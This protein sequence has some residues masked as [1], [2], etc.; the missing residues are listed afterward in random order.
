MN[1]MDLTK[2][3]RAQ[4]DKNGYKD[5][6]MKVIGDVPWSTVDPNNDM[7]TASA[8]MYDAFGVKLTA[9]DRGESRARTVRDGRDT[10][11]PTCSTAARWDKESRR[12][13]ECRSAGEPSDSAGAPMPPPSSTSLKEAGKTYGMAGA[14]KSVATDLYNYAGLN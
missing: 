3:I 2:K 6:E 1:G 10:G 9:Y 14:E 11:H 7:N 12:K 4:L 13:S 8:K 5:V